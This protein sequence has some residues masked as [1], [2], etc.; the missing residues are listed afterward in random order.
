MDVS[1][2]SR[3]E[4]LASEMA[5]QARTVEDL[6]GLMRLMM[7][8]ALERMLNTEMDVHL[9][10]KTLASA[11][12]QPLSERPAAS[13]PSLHGECSTSPPAKRPPNRR[14]GR[15]Q[16]TVQGGN[17]ELTIA[18]P[19]DRD[20]LFEPQIVGK[21]QRRGPGFDEKILGAYGQGVD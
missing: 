11:A 2:R 6:N 14:N 17:G 8:S 5:G 10:R 16:K 7:K 4:E 12:G 20:G 1:L 13:E 21:H 18:T 19:R 3:A 9:G 15:S